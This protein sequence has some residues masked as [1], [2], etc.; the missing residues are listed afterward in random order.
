[1]QNLR[2]QIF[3]C[4]SA[5]EMLIVF[6]CRWSLFH[7]IKFFKRSAGNGN[8]LAY[9]TER[10]FDQPYDLCLFLLSHILYL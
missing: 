4:M 1:M 3:M 9:D 7:D 10:R 2:E 5:R 6:V 8:N